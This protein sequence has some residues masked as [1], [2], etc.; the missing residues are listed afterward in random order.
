MYYEIKM[1]MWDKL[2]LVKQFSE[3]LFEICK[4]L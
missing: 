3:Y 1:T 4:F 2:S